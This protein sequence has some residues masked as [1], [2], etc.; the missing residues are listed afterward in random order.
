CVLQSV[1]GR[2]P[3]RP[4]GSAPRSQRV[5]S[6]PGRAEHLAERL[7]EQV[8]GAADC[9][10]SSHGRASISGTFRYHGGRDAQERNAIMTIHD[11]YRAKHAK[12]AALW[13]RARR[14]IPGGL[15]PDIR[16][17]SPFPTYLR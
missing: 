9:R 7:A 15:T 16:P 8:D 17:L 4:R 3:S 13:E 6:T 12:S 5:R 10:G 11:E 2:G 14:S 1:A